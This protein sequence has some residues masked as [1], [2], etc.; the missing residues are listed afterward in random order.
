MTLARRKTITRKKTFKPG[1][2]TKA[3]QKLPVY[4]MPQQVEAFEANKANKALQAGPG[5]RGRIYFRIK[6]EKVNVQVGDVILE[7]DG[8][9][10][11][12]EIRKGSACQKTAVIICD[13][14]DPEKIKDKQILKPK[15]V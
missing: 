10:Q 2:R 5:K 1:K 11:V 6:K 4:K 3:K 8:L 7:T 13:A 15:K 9:Y 14:L 12:K